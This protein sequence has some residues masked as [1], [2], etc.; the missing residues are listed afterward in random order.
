M[1]ITLTML[2]YLALPD[3]TALSGLPCSGDGFSGALNDE[4]RIPGQEQPILVRGIRIYDGSR[5]PKNEGAPSLLYLKKQKDSVLFLCGGKKILMDTGDTGLGFAEVFNKLEEAF[6]TLRDWDMRLHQGIIENKGL[7]YMLDVSEDI[8]RRPLS[9]TDSGY[10]LI[11]YSK[12]WPDGDP[13]FRDLIVKGYLPADAI[14][15]LDK[16]GFIF[17]KKAIVFRKGIEGLSCPMLNGTVFVE[18]DYRYMLAVLFPDGDY[19]EGVYELFAFLLGQLSLYLDANRDASRIRRFAWTSL[20]ADLVEGKCASAEF[21][22]R[23]RYSG[24]PEDRSYQ[25]VSVRRKDGTMREF[26]RDRLEQA[27]TDEI[28]F[29][30]GDCVF[31]LLADEPPAGRLQPAMAM[32]SGRFD[33]AL[34]GRHAA[35]LGDDRA[36]DRTDDR[37][38]SHIG[39][40]ADGIASMIALS[41]VGN[42]PFI[43]VSD[44]FE[45]LTD[46]HRACLQ[47]NAAYALGLWISQNRTL[48]KLG[49]ASKAYDRNIFY[50]SEYYPYDLITMTLPAFDRNSPASAPILGSTALFPAFR[51]L[52]AEDRK[53]AVGNLRLLYAYLKNDCS[54]TRTAAELFMHRNNVI[55]RISRLEETLGLSLADEQ[56]KASFRMSFLAL[57]L[58]D[59]GALP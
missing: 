42:H 6:I 11:A 27:L 45:T 50:Y 46:L 44:R 7:Q 47:T 18:Q 32:S 20:L 22:E 10:K 59:P 52:L 56:V 26:F 33:M 39:G 13:I 31:V 35:G 29:V 14:A 25:L 48:E 12:K 57:E 38:D 34:A 41:T 58:M 51:A 15:Q 36:D 49:I 8:F 3:C 37:A 16:A 43:C 24:L 30:H 23:N 1:D 40:R 9:I 17:E 4:Y 19:S 54:K 2:L 28:V 55:Y 5:A 21:T 53:S